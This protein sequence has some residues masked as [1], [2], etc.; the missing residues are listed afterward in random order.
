MA[1]SR[2][3]RRVVSE[4]AEDYPGVSLD[5][6]LVDAAAMF[7][8]QARRGSTSS[9]P[10][11][12]SG[13]SSLMRQRCSQARWGCFR[14]RLGEPGSL[15]SSSPSTARHLTSQERGKANPYAT[16]LSAAMM[17]R[18]SLGVPDVAEAIEQGVPPPWRPISDPRRRRQEDD[19]R[20]DEG[21]EQ[22]GRGGR[23]C[24]MSIKLSIRRYVMVPSE[25]ASA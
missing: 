12:S 21:R 13:T 9:L 15:A 2:L 22:V 8:V 25:R 17:F 18:H 23:G 7:L 14:A 6:I 5:H 24:G 20:S 10:R 11:T 3:W 16:I 1:T 19:R 4:V